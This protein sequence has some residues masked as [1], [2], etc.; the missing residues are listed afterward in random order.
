MMEWCPKC[1]IKFRERALFWFLLKLYWFIVLCSMMLEPLHVMSRVNS[2]CQ[3]H[4]N[5]WAVNLYLPFGKTVVLVKLC[6]WI[7]VPTH[8][9]RTFLVMLL[10]VLSIILLQVC[11]KTFY[12]SLWQ[13]SANYIMVLSV[14]CDTKYSK[15]CLEFL[16]NILALL[17]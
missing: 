4:R 11:S 14:Y 3:E 1:M 13:K 5:S 17:W 9:L 7:L 16:Q 6:M 15:I 10:H 2:R 12:S 8:C